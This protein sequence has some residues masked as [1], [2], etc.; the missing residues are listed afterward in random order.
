M[1]IEIKD[2]GTKEFY[3]EVVSVMIQY[4]Q[5]IRKPQMKYRDAFK[6]Y[7]TMCICMGVLFGLQL[8]IGF[9]DE[10]DALT[11]TAL[12]VVACAALVVFLYDRVMMK[13]VRGFIEDDRPSVVTLDE[14]GI[15]I[16]KG[17][18]QIVRLA[19]DNVAFVRAFRESVCFFSKD[20][21]RIVL[22]V[23]KEYESEINKFLDDNSID[24]IR[25]E[26]V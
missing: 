10:F 4:P 14:M 9:I 16:N 23:T 8:W 24:V 5:L 1:R 12:A 13:Q 19:W 22:A 6:S 11:V 2:K 20:N 25:I 26:R 3:K 7:R 15:E 17:D 18:S 21:S